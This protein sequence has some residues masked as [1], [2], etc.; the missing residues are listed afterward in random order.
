MMKIF[1]ESGK[2]YWMEGFGCLR[3][4]GE[5]RQ[6]RP[7]HLICFGWGNSANQNLSESETVSPTIKATRSGEPAIVV[8]NDQGGSVMDISD[9][10]GCLRAQEHGH[11][12]V[13]CHVAAFMGGQ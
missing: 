12:P 8:L 9:K 11:S 6:S 13:I 1:N 2:G 5:N 4:E 3:A 7:N 10:A